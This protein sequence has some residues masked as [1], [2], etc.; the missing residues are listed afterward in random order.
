MRREVQ[1]REEKRGGEKRAEGT[2]KE[3]ENRERE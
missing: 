1:T 2:G 3:M